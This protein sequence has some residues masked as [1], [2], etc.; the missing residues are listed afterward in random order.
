LVSAAPKKEPSQAQEE[1]E[2]SV[3]GGV[4]KSLQARYEIGAENV[5]CHFQG[6]SVAEIAGPTVSDSLQNPVCS[7]LGISKGPGGPEED[8]ERGEEEKTPKGKAEYL[9]FAAHSPKVQV[10]ADSSE[11]GC[12]E[13][14]GTRKTHG[15]EGLEDG[16]RSE[17]LEQKA[18]ARKKKETD[19]SQK[20]ETSDSKA[21]SHQS[22]EKGE[23][24]DDSKV[25]SVFRVNKV[26]GEE[27]F[28]SLGVSPGP[29]EIEEGVTIVGEALSDRP[30]PKK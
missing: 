24:R 30:V 15:W 10:K 1:K 19:E 8:R 29:S 6:I 26:G 5:S 22:G 7:C 3:E 12:K 11:D 27:E 21:G 9:S 4:R 2:G 23:Q 25:E 13:A 18:S 17:E 14:N 16:Q 20:R 28:A